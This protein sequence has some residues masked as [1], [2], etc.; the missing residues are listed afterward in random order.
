MNETPP[1]PTLYSH[2]SPFVKSVISTFPE[3]VGSVDVKPFAILTVFVA[4]SAVAR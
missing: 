3:P 2:T 1:P 4:L